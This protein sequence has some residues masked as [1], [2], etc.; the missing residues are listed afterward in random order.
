MPRPPFSI[1]VLLGIL[2]VF[3][4]SCVMFWLHVRRWT[5]NR[6]WVALRDWANG[7]GFRLSAA[8]RTA[9]PAPLSELTAPPPDALV[10]LA[11]DG[12]VL[13]QL[14]TPGA[15]AAAEGG[16]GAARPARWN[17][18]VRDLPAYWPTTALRPAAHERSLA[19]L[20]NLEAFP[21]LLSSDRYTIHGADSATARAVARSMLV[22]LLPHDLGLV[23]HARHLLL[24]FS[25]RPF[26][27]IELSRVL[28]LVDQL[29][30]HLPAGGAARA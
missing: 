29:I 9:A 30:A 22:A 18:L 2:A 15:A 27:G 17:V 14:E 16:G 4:A 21:A 25:A 10:S 24:D 26:D 12:V 3:G 23:L 19:D 28:A 20:F 1:W 8:G 5:R 6:P 11:R 7:H 13:V